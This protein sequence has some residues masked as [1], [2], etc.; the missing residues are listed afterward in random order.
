MVSLTPGGTQREGLGACTPGVRRMRGQKVSGGRGAHFED[1]GEL[2]EG[3][4]GPGQVSAAAGTFQ[5]GS[6]CTGAGGG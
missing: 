1:S 3:R 4:V 5:P 2:E 6:S